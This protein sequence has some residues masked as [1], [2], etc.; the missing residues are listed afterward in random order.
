M[1]DTKKQL[2]E[3]LKKELKCWQAEEDAAFSSGQGSRHY[4]DIPYIQEKMSQI[5]RWLGWVDEQEQR[6]DAEVIKTIPLPQHKAT[7]PVKTSP[8]FIA[9][10]T[11]IDAKKLVKC[12]DCG[13]VSET[14]AWSFEHNKPLCTSCYDKKFTDVH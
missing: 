4:D 12:A 9:Y 14:P 5:Q 7:A 3:Y 8:E 1:S 11:A 2:I 6:Y 10:L 13:E